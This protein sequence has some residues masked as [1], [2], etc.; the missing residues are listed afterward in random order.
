MIRATGRRCHSRIVRFALG[1]LLAYGALVLLMVLLED[2][3]IYHPSGC[4]NWCEPPSP[5]FQDVLVESTSGDRIHAWYL[6]RAGA[7]SVFLYSHGNAGNLSHRGQAAMEWSRELNV[8]VLMYD[9]PGFGKSTG[10]PSETG[11]YAAANAM[12]QWLVDDLKA[13]PSSII[14]FGKSLGG[15]MAVDLASRNDHRALILARAFTT[16][17][18]AGADRFWFVPVRWLAR[19]QFPNLPKLP[20]C[21]RPTFIHHGAA[22]NVVSIRHARD[23]FAAAAEPKAMLIDPRGTHGGSYPPE[24]FPRIRSFLA[25]YAPD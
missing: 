4:A 2:Q 21:R 7:T 18:E 1:G 3:L 14:L 13:K 17:P 5:L 10:K 20:R 22:D 11:C 24:L 15:A 16:L 6:P 9:Y 23:L 25:Q 19:S 8:S 12:W